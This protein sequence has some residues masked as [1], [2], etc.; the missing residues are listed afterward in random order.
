MKRKPVRMNKSKKLFTKGALNTKSINTNPI[1]QR[2]GLR[3]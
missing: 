1:P 2:G 3:L